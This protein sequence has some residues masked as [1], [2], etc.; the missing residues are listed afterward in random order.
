MNKILKILVP[1]LLIVFLGFCGLVGLGFYRNGQ[2]DK[3]DV[4]ITRINSTKITLDDVMGKYLPKEPDQKQNDATVEGID[5]NNN[6]IRDDVELAIF[7]KY[8]NSAKMRS[9]MLQYAQV[10]QLQLTQIFNSVTLVATIKKEN[11]AYFCLG[12]VDNKNLDNN[13]EEIEQWVL[14]KDFR[15]KTREDAYKYMTS[16]TSPQEKK[17]D[18]DLSSLPN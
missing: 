1:I 12:Y 7:K 3:T 11:I 16:Y 6:Y 4:A 2:K 17:C 10:L 13:Q 5:A 15:K 9:A 8:P 14:N 18:V